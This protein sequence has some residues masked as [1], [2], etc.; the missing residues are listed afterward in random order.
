MAVHSLTG[1]QV[2]MKKGALAGVEQG[3]LVVLLRPAELALIAR[4]A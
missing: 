1:A 4:A 3:E 2:R